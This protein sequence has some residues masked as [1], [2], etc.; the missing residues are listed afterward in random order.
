MKRLVRLCALA[1]LVAIGATLSLGV[2]PNDGWPHDDFIGPSAAHAAG[3]AC[4]NWFD[5]P[6][7]VYSNGD[8]R[9]VAGG[10]FYDTWQGK[11]THLN[12]DIQSWRY[13]STGSDGWP[14]GHCLREIRYSGWV[15][16]GSYGTVYMSYS[17]S[18]CG[19]TWLTGGTGWNFEGG[20]AYSSA[21]FD[22]SGCGG[23]NGTVVFY[24]KN[25]DWTPF[26]PDQVPYATTSL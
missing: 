21:W 10:Q 11:Y 1:A 3:G 6:G 24:G 25:A 2:A 26:W 14:A 23:P 15:D 5:S 8:Y 12:A 4:G 13:T 9:A 22:Y 20:H 18:I 19:T 7:T 16:D 17:L